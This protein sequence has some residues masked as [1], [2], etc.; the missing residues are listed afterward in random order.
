[1]SLA[2]LGVFSKHWAGMPIVI[3]NLAQSS[4]VVLIFVKAAGIRSWATPTRLRAAR[5]RDMLRFGMPL[6]LEGIAHQVS[7]Y[8][9]NL[10]ISRFFG[11]AGAGIY[12]MAYNLADIPAAHVG[13]QVALVLLPSMAELPPSPAAGRARACVGAARD[14]HLPA[15]VRSG[16]GRASV[17]RDDPAGRPLASG[18]TAARRTLGAIDLPARS[19]GCSPRTWSRTPRR[20]D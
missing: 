6:G 9:D 18:R 10:A 7:C 1:M 2:A 11:A 8:W 20:T 4:V 16:A 5:F 12:N 17:D 13:E 3:G 15:R 19:R 14:R